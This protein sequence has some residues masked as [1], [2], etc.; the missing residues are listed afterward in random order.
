MSENGHDL[1]I[2]KSITQDYHYSIV[3]PVGRIKDA[4]EDAI[5]LIDNIGN[6]CARRGVDTKIIAASIRTP[7]QAEAVMLAGAYAVVIFYDVF[8]GM[9]ESQLTRTSIEGFE[10]DE[11]RFSFVARRDSVIQP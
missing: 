4:G 3:V 11:A 8:L 10:R 1:F 9:F 2:A 5:G 7:V 6:L